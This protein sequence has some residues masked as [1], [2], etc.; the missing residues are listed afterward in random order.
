[1]AVPDTAILRAIERK[2]DKENLDPSKLDVLV[3]RG[4]VTLTGMP[5]E[6]V[7]QRVVDGPSREKFKKELKRI[8]GVTEV[9]FHMSDMASYI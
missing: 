6:R 9:I 2:I 5:V 4:H 8:D 7:T 3:I 1:M